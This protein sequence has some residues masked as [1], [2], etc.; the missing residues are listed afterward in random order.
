MS[1]RCTVCQHPRRKEIDKAILTGN[2]TLWEMAK[3]FSL[4]KQALHRH[5]ANGHT[6]QLVAK[7]LDAKDVAMAD[8]LLVQI[9]HLVEEAKSILEMAKENGDLRIACMAIGQ[10]RAVLET[11]AKVSGELKDQSH[12]TVN[13]QINN[14]QNNVVTTINSLDLSGVSDERILRALE[15]LRG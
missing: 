6:S 11:L 3:R 12:Q 1:R 13:V 2:E 8:S 4:S 7:A 9:K 5:K 14:Q 15:I 10:M